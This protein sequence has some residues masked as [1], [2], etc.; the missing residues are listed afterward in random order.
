M[1]FSLTASLPEP[2]AALLATLLCL[3]VIALYILVYYVGFR[4]GESSKIAGV[5]E[6][7]LE[8]REEG[9]ELD[10]QRDSKK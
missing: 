1:G 5:L 6:E 2:G 9:S 4:N 3:A 7:I 8:G 10:E